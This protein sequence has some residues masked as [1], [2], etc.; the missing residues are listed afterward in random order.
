[1]FAGLGKWWASESPDRGL[2]RLAN[3]TQVLLLVFALYT[4]KYTVIPI[5]ERDV[6]T[7][8]NAQLTKEV[9]AKQAEL[10]QITS[11]TTAATKLLEAQ[12]TEVTRL[13]EQNARATKALQ[14]LRGEV[15][16]IQVASSRVIRSL[17]GER[18]RDK[19][20]LKLAEKADA[21]CPIDW[22]GT[23]TDLG[24]CIVAVAKLNGFEKQLDRG[25]WIL[26]EGWAR[27]EGSRAALVHAQD[28]ERNAK[29]DPRAAA[30]FSSLCGDSKTNDD[31]R[32]VC[33]ALGAVV[34]DQRYWVKRHSLEVL[35]RLTID[36]VTQR[37]RDRIP[38][39]TGEPR[40]LAP[41]HPTNP[42]N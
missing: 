1:V 30:L 18:Q 35:G 39:P 25:D 29:L 20:L 3:L 23:P 21:I 24:E 36:A 26:L 10:A 41:T 14:D 27:Y 28:I 40:L 33:N 13:N 16:N 8:S 7:E 38:A 9:S 19:V 2:S 37:V 4:L 32:E 42:G 12:Q 5:Y 11:K 17:Q 22:V 15:Q 34:A 6:L 31:G